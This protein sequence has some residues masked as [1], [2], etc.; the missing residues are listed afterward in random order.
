MDWTRK[1]LIDIEKILGWVS[2]VEMIVI[3]INIING[4]LMNDRIVVCF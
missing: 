3:L 4:D 1:S 2:K